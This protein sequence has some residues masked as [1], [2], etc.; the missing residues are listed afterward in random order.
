MFLLLKWL[1]KLKYGSDTVNE[2]EE[3]QKRPKP[4]RRPQQ[5]TRR[6]KARKRG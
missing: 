5:R 6:P 4:Q 2:F 1:A 3:K